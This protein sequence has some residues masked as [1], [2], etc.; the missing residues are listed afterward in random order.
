MLIAHRWYSY[1]WGYPILLPRSQDVASAKPTWTYLLTIPASAPSA[2]CSS[3]GLLINFPWHGAVRPCE[4]KTVDGRAS[5][6]LQDVPF[7]MFQSYPQK[8]AASLSHVQNQMA[9]NIG[10]KPWSLWNRPLFHSSSVQCLG[11]R[12]LPLNVSSVFTTIE[13]NHF[14]EWA[15]TNLQSYRRILQYIYI[16]L[17]LELSARVPQAQGNSVGSLQLLV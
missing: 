13:Y 3:Y 9:W 1:N 7:D 2:S 16:N 15:I 8:E 10:G 6:V 17:I 14:R 4:A 11:S 5:N 12:C